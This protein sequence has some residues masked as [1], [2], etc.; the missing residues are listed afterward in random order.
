[1]LVRSYFLV[2]FFMVPFFR[3]CIVTDK[4][5]ERGLMLV[6][7]PVNNGVFKDIEQSE[8]APDGCMSL[9]VIIISC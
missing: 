6:Q 4:H 2:P 9:S 7:F 3:T 5:I 1:M 8:M